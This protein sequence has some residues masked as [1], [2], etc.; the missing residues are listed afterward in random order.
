MLRFTIRKWVEKKVVYS[1]N[2]ETKEGGTAASPQVPL[3]GAGTHKVSFRCHYS[4]NSV[5]VMSYSHDQR[6]FGVEITRPG[7]TVTK[8]WIQLINQETRS[9]PTDGRRFVRCEKDDWHTHAIDLEAVRSELMLP[10]WDEIGIRI[11]FKFDTKD[12]ENNDG[13]A[14]W[15]VDNI[16]I[17][18]TEL[19]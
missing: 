13:G 17:L 16:E 19:E 7:H 8:R 11:L 10:T 18:K 14:G 6:S 3:S 12:D 4:L 5:D 1:Y 2:T 9:D 15:F